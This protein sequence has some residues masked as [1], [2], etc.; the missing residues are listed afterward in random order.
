M[1]SNQKKAQA[2]SYTNIPGLQVTNDPN[3]TMDESFSSLDLPGGHVGSQPHSRKSTPNE[4]NWM[5]Q[6]DLN[7]LFRLFKKRP[8][9]RYRVC[10]DKIIPLACDLL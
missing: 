3:T 4:S 8:R 10:N 7:R 6:V 1:Y 5:Q 9:K 2:L